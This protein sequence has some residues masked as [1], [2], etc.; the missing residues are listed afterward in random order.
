MPVWS[1]DS[2]KLQILHLLLKKQLTRYSMVSFFIYYLVNQWR[3]WDL[4]P[5]PSAHESPIHPAELPSK[6]DRLII[7]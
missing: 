7:V 5:H 1:G 6:L 3:E 2:S 4:N